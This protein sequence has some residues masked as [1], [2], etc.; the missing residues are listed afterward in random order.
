MKKI[1]KEV[2][3]KQLVEV[4]SDEDAKNMLEQYR[5]QTEEGSDD[6]HFEHYDWSYNDDGCCC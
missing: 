2:K 3:E 5:S 4:I 6:I 1:A